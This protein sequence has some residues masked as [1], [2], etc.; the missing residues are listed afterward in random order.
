MAE[1]IYL[2]REV[3][4]TMNNDIMWSQQIQSLNIEEL[5]TFLTQL[6]TMWKINEKI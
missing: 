6:E 4:P 5:M 3:D 2:N 1:T